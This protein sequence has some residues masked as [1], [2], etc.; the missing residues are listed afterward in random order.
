M[1]AA[2]QDVSGVIF[3]VMK[4]CMFGSVAVVEDT[5][6]VCL[7]EFSFRQFHILTLRR[8]DKAAEDAKCSSEC[9]QDK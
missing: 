5:D 8:V 9:C 2:V 3:T 6:F 1:P 4:V 7:G